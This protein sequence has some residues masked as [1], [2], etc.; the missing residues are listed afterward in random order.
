MGPADTKKGRA[1]RRLVVLGFVVVAAATAV[2]LLAPASEAA[3][4][5]LCDLP[6][7][8][9]HG[10]NYDVCSSERPNVLEMSAQEF[11]VQPGATFELTLTVQRWEDGGCGII[12]QVFLLVSWT[13]S[14]PP[15]AGYYHGLYNGQP[16][17]YPGVTFTSTVSLQA[18]TAPGVYYIWVGGSAD[19]S[20]EQGVR[21]YDAPLTA[22]AH[23]RVVVGDPGP[24]WTEPET[25]LGPQ[26][27][28]QRPVLVQHGT[29]QWL[30]VVEGTLV[31]VYH[32]AMSTTAWEAP[33]TVFEYRGFSSVHLLR[34]SDG[35]L[36]AAAGL[37]CMSF[38][39]SIPIKASTDG[40]RTWELRST[41]DHPL[42][43]YYPTLLEDAQ[44]RLGLV[45]YAYNGGWDTAVTTW[46]ADGGRNWGPRMPWLPGGPREGGIAAL[47]GTQGELCVVASQEI[48]LP[49]WALVF[50]CSR[51]GGAT[52]S[53]AKVLNDGPYTF[54]WP[55]IGEDAQG[56]FWVVYGSY[57]ERGLGS[58]ELR[59]VVSDD[60]GATW[61]GPV[62]LTFDSDRDEVP[63]LT[64]DERAGLHLLWGKVADDGVFMVVHSQLGATPLLDPPRLEAILNGVPGESG[65]W[66]SPVGVALV[67]APGSP[68]A[69]E[70][71]YAVDG[72]PE[73]RYAAPFRV[74]GEG[75]HALRFRGI[76]LEG[77][78]GSWEDAAL[79]IDTRAPTGTSVFNGTPGRAGWWRSPVTVHLGG[80]DPS[81]GSGY[82][83]AAASLDGSPWAQLSSVVLSGNGRHTLMTSA[84]DVAGNA[85][86]PRLDEV[87]IDAAPPAVALLEPAR[88]T[89]WLGSQSFRDPPL[90]E[91]LAAAEAQLQGPD[92][93]AWAT[94]DVPVR[95]DAADNVD[96]SG[97]FVVRVLV[98][99][100]PRFEARG[101]AT[102]TWPAG[103]EPA[104]VHLLAVEAED[105][106]GN[107]A[108]V[109][110]LVRTFPTSQPGVARTIAAALAGIPAAEANRSEG[111]DV[112]VQR[113]VIPE[114]PVPIGPT[115]SIHEEACPPGFTDCIVIQVP[116]LGQ[117]TVGPHAVDLPHPIG[118]QAEA[119]VYAGTSGG[120]WTTQQ[121]PL[122]L[123]L[124]ATEAPAAVMEATLEYGIVNPLV[125]LGGRLSLPPPLPP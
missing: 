88:G 38:C 54:D 70:A 79:S 90:P 42:D 60:R 45:Y 56:R 34:H 81:P 1:D 98:D 18:P 103:Q 41:I 36:Y 20:I 15:P 78:V 85:E 47:L 28:L 119:S 95:F 94:L 112:V 72:G 92:A 55:T 83:H 111:V 117:P 17:P 50:A 35:T 48:M 32:R 21:A 67:E 24:S 64:R 116:S 2:V 110:R 25:V 73:A 101:P 53:E 89:L 37:D 121:G 106:A 57:E 58:P 107:V 12:S 29:E 30:L 19:Y 96:G 74:D 44:G 84:A 124:V 87:A 109:S 105:V 65:W 62:R 75:A 123:E 9:K 97:L 100:V 10:S 52:W 99:G 14:W 3:S 31:R 49:G 122:G 13:P 71:H 69:A 61:T 102:W 77:A 76:G 11:R 23:A 4:P 5:D 114:T 43:D 39:A 68:P 86:P 40:G 7:L 27:S 93:D 59:Y 120:R 33:V 63:R 108:S 51:D 82:N 113:V 80:S 104:G 66:R 16:C 91:L 22:R 26:G 8:L 118:A 115:P 125:P 6:A 46:S